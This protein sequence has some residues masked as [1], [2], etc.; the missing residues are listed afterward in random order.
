VPLRPILSR[1]EKLLRYELSPSAKGGGG[2][3]ERNVQHPDL[4]LG[5][6]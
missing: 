1:L 4:V 2:G 6:I 3:G 5:L